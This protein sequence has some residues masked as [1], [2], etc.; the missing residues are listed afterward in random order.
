MHGQNPHNAPVMDGSPRKDWGIRQ[1]TG[2][3]RGPGSV[4]RVVQAPPALATSQTDFWDIMSHCLKIV[5]FFFFPPIFLVVQQKQ[6]RPSCKTRA[7]HTSR[8]PALFR[9]KKRWGTHL[10]TRTTWKRSS[11]KTPAQLARV[12]EFVGSEKNGE[13]LVQANFW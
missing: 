2:A 5:L 3:K 1:P 10:G 13:I 12:N 4:E 7:R 11:D 9:R 6:H 8:R